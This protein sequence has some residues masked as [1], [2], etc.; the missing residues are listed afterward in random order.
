MGHVCTAFSTK[1]YGTEGVE[2]TI[3]AN[4]ILI[5]DSIITHNKNPR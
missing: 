4:K 3:T 2:N 1:T 5:S